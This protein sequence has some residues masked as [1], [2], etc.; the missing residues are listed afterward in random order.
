[1]GDQRQRINVCAQSPFFTCV[2][3]DQSRVGPPMSVT[4]FETTPTDML[5]GQFDLDN[6]LYVVTL[7]PNDSQLHQVGK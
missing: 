3:Q 4:V 7:F 2:I 1:M 6:Q 5:T